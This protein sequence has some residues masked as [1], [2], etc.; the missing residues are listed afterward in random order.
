MPT[1]TAASVTLKDFV[2]DHYHPQTQNLM[3]LQQHGQMAHELVISEE[4]KSGLKSSVL[5]VFDR[6]N[7]GRAERALRKTYCEIVHKILLCDFPARWPDLLETLL[8]A[9][10]TATDIT[11]MAHVLQILYLIVDRRFTAVRKIPC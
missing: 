2:L 3:Q 11:G 4:D 6:L 8:R 1:R 9:A 7:I 5:L 10:E